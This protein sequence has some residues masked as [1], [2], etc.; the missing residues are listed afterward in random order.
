MSPVVRAV[1]DS[2]ISLLAADDVVVDVLFDD[3]RIWSFWSHRDTEPVGGA[4]SP[5]RTA[6]W[7]RPLLRFLDGRTRL[8]IQTHVD[9]QVL[10]DEE[11]AFGSGTEPIRVV[12]GHGV[13]LSID[14]S[15]R[16]QATF[17]TRSASQV[18]PL[19][20]SVETVLAALH[21]AGV[22][23]FPAYGTLLGAVRDGALIGHD[24]DA[25]L[26]YVSRHTHPVDVIRESF[27]LQRELTGM[28]FP[29]ARYSGAGF[30]VLVREGDGHSRGLDV[31]GGFFDD[32]RL[33]LLGEI[34]TPFEKE[35]VFPLGTT[36]LEGRELPAPAEPERLLEATYGPSWRTPDPAFRY[37][38][39]PSTTQRMDGWFRGTI[40]QR[41]DWDRRY[42]S[43]RFRRPIRRP[44]P[45]A[46]VVLRREADAALVVDLGCAR[47][48]NARW[49]ARKGL[50]VL[51]LDYS[52]RAF[53]YADQPQRRQDLDLEFAPM[54]L[55]ELRHTLAYGARV[56]AT[57]GRRVVMARHVADVLTAR[58]REN[59]WRF[60][61][62]ACGHG[63]HAYLEFL[64]SRTR[65]DSWAQQNLLRP[66]DPDEVEAALVAHGGTVV[67]R[68]SIGS[69]KM[70]VR[71]PRDTFAE[72]RRACRMVVEW[73]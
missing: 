44:A 42:Q 31:F 41:A 48:T 21:R 32:G 57:P 43:V 73:S 56:G 4:S 40:V 61:E 11:R 66:L 13:E 30:K 55:L 28:G 49:L 69:R 5:E 72:Q 38:T 47:G 3:R 71:R 10:V 12:N 59:L 51:G 20:D 36:S 16:L 6:P 46:R 35:W 67:R 25:D 9:G 70:G 34:R 7:P 8:R 60:L 37:E 27:R 24:S 54:N 45:L 58:G 39:P 18:A 19:L 52:E 33:V 65:R 17:D 29:V 14:M 63:G 53:E 2:G 62:M 64:T 26:G 1:D 50:N 22:D 15:G 68:R 23:A